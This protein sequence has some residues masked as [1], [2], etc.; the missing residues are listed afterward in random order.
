MP[1]HPKMG[2]KFSLQT[3]RTALK[4][5]GG[6]HSNLYQHSL[7]ATFGCSH[8]GERDMRVIV[9]N[10]LIMVAL[11]TLLMTGRH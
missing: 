2:V 3:I 4:I 1:S 6:F 7:T 10:V 9:I 11:M 5:W 8:R